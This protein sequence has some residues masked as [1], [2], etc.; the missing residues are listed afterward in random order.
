[1]ST[2]AILGNW[3]PE[4]SHA[5]PKNLFNTICGFDPVI[6]FRTCTSF[7]QRRDPGATE[8]G[9]TERRADIYDPNFVL[10]LLAALMV[11]DEPITSMQ[12]VDLCRTNVLCLALSSLSSKRLTMRQL[13]YASLTTAYVRLTEVDFQERAQ[14]VYTLDL[15]RNIFPQPFTAPSDLIPRLPTYATLLLSHAIRDIFVPATPLY[16]L[17]SRFLLQRPEFDPRDVPML[18]TLLYSS[19][20]EWK[21]ERGWVL[22][23]LADGMRSSEDW[24]VLKRRHTWDLL[25]SLFQS[26]IEDRTLR[27]SILEVLINASAN[28]HAATSLLLNSSILSWIYMQL[29]WILPGEPLAYLKI[30]ENM[31]VVVD[32]EQVEKATAGH[33]RDVVA[34]IVNKIAQDHGS[35]SSLV[36]LGSRILLRL[37]TTPKTAPQTFTEPLRTILRFLCSYEATLAASTLYLD[38]LASYDHDHLHASR[39]LLDPIQGATLDH[40]ISS[41]RALWRVAMVTEPAD[42]NISGIL[43][44]RMLLLSGTSFGSTQDVIWARHQLV[45]AVITPSA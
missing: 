21:R 36:H 7:P 9:G 16:P 5:Q 28:K 6:M 2:I 29:N 18:Y 45:E 12:W 42:S 10:P 26:A 30:V 13:G 35:D 17:I 14:L 15:L 4:A 40:W 31:A 8:L 43:N 39:D 23:F 11:S 24:K 20:G 27:L 41:I 1:M 44:S 37:A 22:R 25:A 32:H 19:S 33:W 38:E 3:T 34:Q